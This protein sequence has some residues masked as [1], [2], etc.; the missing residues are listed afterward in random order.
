MTRETVDRLKE[1][2]FDR[3]VRE[4]DGLANRLD[5]LDERVGGDEQLQRSIARVAVGA[6]REVEATEHA[7]LADAVAPVVVRTVQAEIVSPHN[8]DALAGA[9]YPK[10][11]QMVRSYVASAVQDLIEDINRRLESGLLRNRLVLRLRSLFSGRSMAELVL[12]DT[13]H[14]DVEEIYLIRRGSGELLHHWARAA[15]GEPVVPERREGEQSNRDTL[16]SGFLTAIT[17]F[18]EEAFDADQEGLR[19]LDLDQHRIYFRTTP[20]HL[21]AARCRGAATTAV[22][23]CID[24]EFLAL[25]EQERLATGNGPADARSAS[26]QR[27]ER[28]E[29]TAQRLEAAIAAREREMR[30]GRSSLALFKAAAGLVLFALLVLVSWQVWV[31]FETMRAQSSADGVL[32]AMP[33]LRGYPL[34]AEA[35]N[36][37]QLVRI[38]GL[39]PTPA[40]RDGLLMRLA[41]V[42]PGAEVRPSIGILPQHDPAGAI[43]SALVRQTLDRLQRRMR[44]LGQVLAGSAARLGSGPRQEA[45]RQAA[46]AL[47]AVA[48][49][50]FGAPAEGGGETHLAALQAALASLAEASAPLAVLAG[51]PRAGSERGGGAASI[52]E[53]AEELMLTAERIAIAA[54]GLERAELAEQERTRALAPLEGEVRALTERLKTIEAQRSALEAL[55]AF[56]RR[57]AVL[58]GEGTDYRNEPD[59]TATLDTLVRLL[60]A[61]PATVRV[62]GYADELGNAQKNLPLSQSRAD[63]VAREIVARGVPPTR[64]LAIGRGSAFANARTDLETSQRRA[65]IEIVGR[66]LDATGQSP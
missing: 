17:A 47:D 29:A 22:E 60:L 24:D 59:A 54:R 13:Q 3:E 56:V 35:E 30:R 16:V 44:E 4:I 46:Q 33:E 9:L 66:A 61:T 37:G 36:R 25:L 53:S 1:L 40:A 21:L 32:A 65:E 18:A 64:V 20:A 43:D 15:P 42:L 63:R 10:I 7:E 58:F 8:Q 55:E 34:R 12:A 19:S 23:R 45:V 57:A 48:R 52:P 38:T 26:A 5:K 14:L 6:L 11:G 39:A 62:V 51:E 28:L 27:A 2:L 41:A 31:T 49:G 50:G